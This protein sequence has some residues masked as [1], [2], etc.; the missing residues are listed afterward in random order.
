MLDVALDLDR[1]NQPWR[2]WWHVERDA[3]GAAVRV[4]RN[5]YWRDAMMLFTAELAASDD[6][7]PVIRVTKMRHLPLD[8]AENVAV[9]DIT[10][11]GAT[12]EELVAAFRGIMP[13]ADARKIVAHL[14][15]A[16]VI[17]LPGRP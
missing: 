3:C 17:E 7:K 12:D 5:T 1:E 6:G 4:L 15:G 10:I 8:V 16:A 11:A 2:A 13:V 9:W 14:R